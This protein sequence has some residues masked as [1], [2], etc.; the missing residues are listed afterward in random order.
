VALRAHFFQHEEFEGP[1]RIANWLHERGWE[2]EG[3]MMHEGA[4]LPALDSADLFI[5]MGG[6][7]SVND[8]DRLP[9]LAAEK[10]FLRAAI[11]ADRAV[12][13]VCLGAQLIANALGARVYPNPAGREVGWHPVR[14]TAD[15][16]STAFEIPS[17][18]EVFH[19]HG[20]TFD[21]P[22]GAVRFAESD[23]CRNQA[24]QVGRAVIGLQFHPEATRESVA[25]LVASC[26]EDLRPAPFV[27]SP[28]RILSAPAA[29]FDAMHGL[30]G[31]ILDRLTRPRA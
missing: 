9:W 18:L 27:Q 24:F 7:M 28:D 14:G 6:G 2:L 19:W 13:G 10:Q 22:A 16:G 15:A 12:L 30:L 23:A 1:G 26:P 3:S 20:E 11:A 17:P 25:A 8:E 31:Q 4:G 29:T 5:F 21:L